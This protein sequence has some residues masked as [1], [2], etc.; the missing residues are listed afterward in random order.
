MKTQNSIIFVKKI[1][2]EYVKDNKYPKDR[3]YFHYTREYR[4][5]AHSICM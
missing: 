5:S 4:G 1:E 2:N 3:Y